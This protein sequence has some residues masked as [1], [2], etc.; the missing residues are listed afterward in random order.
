MYFFCFKQIIIAIQIFCL[1]AL[2]EKDWGMVW[3]HILSKPLS[4]YVSIMIS[5]IVQRKEVLHECRSVSEIRYT[6]TSESFV[7]AM[8]LVK[9][10]KKFEPMIKINK[11]SLSYIPQG[12]LAP[13]KLK[14]FRETQATEQTNQFRFDNMEQLR[15]KEDECLQLMNRIRRKQCIPM[16]DYK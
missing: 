5:F 6:L 15:A 3:D 11:N 14:S 2:S 16:K 4:F 9:K 13:I 1:Q 7:S 10:A 12:D 8:D